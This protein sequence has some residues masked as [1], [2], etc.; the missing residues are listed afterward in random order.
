[1]TDN[2]SEYQLLQRLSNYI[3]RQVTS[4]IITKNFADQKTFYSSF[5]YPTRD[6]SSNLWCFRLVLLPGSTSCNYQ[7]LKSVSIIQNDL[8]CSRSV[9][10]FENNLIKYSNINCGCFICR[11]LD[12]PVQCCPRSIKTTLYWDFFCTMLSG[13]S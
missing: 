7:L 4:W 5:Y 12:F 13:S 8:Q 10:N 1:M 3:F 11:L 6:I 9:F 2:F